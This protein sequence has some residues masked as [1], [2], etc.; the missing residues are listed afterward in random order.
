MREMVIGKRAKKKATLPP[1]RT[2]EPRTSRPIGLHSLARVNTPL[3]GHDLPVLVV[4]PSTRVTTSFSMPALSLSLWASGL[5]L[6]AL[7]CA[8]GN[9]FIKRGEVEED[10][11][12]PDKSVD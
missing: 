10:A 11:F 2:V 6:L 4:V 3:S 8:P 12:R 5:W 9:P 1:I 7:F